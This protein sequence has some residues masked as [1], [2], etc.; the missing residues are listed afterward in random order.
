MFRKGNAVADRFGLLILIA[1][2]VIFGA[3]F[4]ESK[5]EYNNDIKDRT[6]LVNLVRIGNYVT[7]YREQ[8]QGKVPKDLAALFAGFH[9]D[10]PLL[11]C[12]Y[13][14]TVPGYDCNFTATRTNEDIVCWDKN[15][16]RHARTIF[17]GRPD[18][19]RAVLYANGHAKTLKET[20]FRKLRLPY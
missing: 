20:E 11:K 7:N 4:Q 16:H 10:N 6:C 14:R 12:P 3:A 5:T 9:S 19:T 17:S 2:V 8:H 1:L 18:D 15:V 13:S